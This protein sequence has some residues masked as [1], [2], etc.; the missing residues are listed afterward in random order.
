MTT[1]DKVEIAYIK[2]VQYAHA[3][4]P[5]GRMIRALKDAIDA[6]DAALREELAQAHARIAALEGEP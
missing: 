5:L 2:L 1:Q 4:S 3:D 6:H